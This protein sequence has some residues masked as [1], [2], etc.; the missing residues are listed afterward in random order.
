MWKRTAWSCTVVYQSEAVHFSFAVME[1][2]VCVMMSWYLNTKM[3]AGKGR[4]GRTKR[5][6]NGAPKMG[7]GQIVAELSVCFDWKIFCALR[8]V[9]DWV[10]KTVSSSENFTDMHIY[11][12][13]HRR[14]FV[15]FPLIA[16]KGE[17]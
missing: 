8:W 12:V 11:S 5:R 2:S 10:R 6:R 1:P 3:T 9:I 4:E 14:F 17:R 13:E 15:F 7:N 16:P